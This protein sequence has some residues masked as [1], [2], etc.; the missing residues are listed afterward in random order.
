MLYLKA[1]KSG[2]NALFLDVYN[3]GIQCKSKTHK[4]TYKTVD[5]L[6]IEK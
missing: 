6:H 3:F 2:A 5:K 4:I 1:I